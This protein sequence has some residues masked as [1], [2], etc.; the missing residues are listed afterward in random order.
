[1]Y[2]VFIP[3]NFIDQYIGLVL[4]CVGIQISNGNK[5]QNKQNDL[6]EFLL[7]LTG[8]LKKKKKHKMKKKKKTNTNNEHNGK[9]SGAELKAR[10]HCTCAT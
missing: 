10:Q 6:R 9:E 1:M 3:A 4:Y 8:S 7:S 2:R 5:Y